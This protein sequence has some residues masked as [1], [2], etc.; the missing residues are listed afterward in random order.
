MPGET[1]PG[2]MVHH[3]SVPVK[4]AVPKWLR[5]A[6]GIV[7][8]IAVVV[9]LKFYHK[10]SDSA[11]V[12]DAMATWVQSAPG[13][14]DQKTLFDE[15]LAEAHE[16]AFNETY[17]LGG[18]RRSATFDANA[19]ART[20]FTQMKAHA[21]EQGHPEVAQAIDTVRQRYIAAAPR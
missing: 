13:Y 11:E 4:P 18:R 17:R 14:E 7:F 8:V 3:Q 5:T 6:G 19:Y 1:Q 16:E 12:R 9:G 10:G 20:L 15:L 21:M 2:G